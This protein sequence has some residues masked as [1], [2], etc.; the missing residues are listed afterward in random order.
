MHSSCVAIGIVLLMLIHGS[1]IQFT[2]YLSCWAQIIFFNVMSS[3]LMTL[4]TEIGEKDII[5][6]SAE[7]V[8]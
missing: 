8:F 7:T 4:A 5:G 3:C 1:I 6:I 2:Q